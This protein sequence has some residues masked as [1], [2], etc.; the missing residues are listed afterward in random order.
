MEDQFGIPVAY[1]G[2]AFAPFDLI[3]DTMRGT[4]GVLVD[5]LERPDELLGLIDG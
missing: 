5:M 4:E 3:G 2:S 1:T